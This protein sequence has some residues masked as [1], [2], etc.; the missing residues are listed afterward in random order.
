VLDDGLARKS[1]SGGDLTEATK[2]QAQA[3]RA[4]AQDRNQ[5]AA[6]V[7][8]AKSAKDGNALADLGLIATLDGDAV[9]GAALLE[10]AIAKGGL[11]SPDEARLHLGV[12][13]FFAERD[14]QALKTFQS[15]DGTGGVAALA[16]VWA[17]L[18]QSKMAPAPGAKSSS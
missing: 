13:E 9:Q 10:E 6:N 2:L 18:V 8:A 7:R 12:A 4:A 17:L 15:I 14:A 11:K 16:H 5:A 3:A 1:F